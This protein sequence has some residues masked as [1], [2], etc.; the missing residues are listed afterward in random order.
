MTGCTVGLGAKENARSEGAKVRAG[1]FSLSCPADAVNLATAT[2]A[3]ELSS[4]LVAGAEL[5]PAIAA[6]DFALIA[7]GAL[8]LC[9]ALV[10]AVVPLAAGTV[11]DG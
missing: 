2:V 1:F 10:A 11:V 3:L 4:A 8:V 5:E 9:S 7:A 6:Y